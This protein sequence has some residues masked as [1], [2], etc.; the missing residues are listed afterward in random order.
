MEERFAL[1]V[2]D[3]DNVAT[4][5][6]SP[7][8]G[9]RLRIDDSTGA[10]RSMDVEDDIPYGHKIA[11]ADIPEGGAII[12]YGEVIGRAVAPIARGRHVHVHNVVSLRGRGDL[13]ADACG[14]VSHGI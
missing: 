9:S 5:F 12:K 14:E 2:H 6:A 10:S 3:R 8:K 7:E 4:V 11:L 1:Q 13:A